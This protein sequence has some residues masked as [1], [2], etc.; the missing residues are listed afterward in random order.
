MSELLT[1]RPCGSWSTPISSEVVVRAVREITGV[2]VDGESV[3]WSELRPEEGGRT[4]IVRLDGRG[5]LHEVLPEGS[6]A[7]SAVHEYG[8]G[9]WWVRDGTVWFT[10]WADQRLYRL[11][12][13][14]V[15]EPV[16]PVPSPPRSVRWADGDVHPEGERVVVVRETHH[17]RRATE[18]VNEVVVLSLE[19]GA[20]EDVAV[21]G[22]AVG[23]G[24]VEGGVGVVVSGPDFVSTPRW[25]PDGESLC[26]LEWNHPDMP[27]DSTL[28]RVRGEDGGV[29]EVAGGPEESVFQP[30]WAPDGSLWFCSDRTGWWT[31]YRWT[32]SEGVRCMVDRPAEVGGPQWAFGTSRYDFLSD[33]RVVLASRDG[34]ADSLW[35]LS[36]GDLRELAAGCTTITSI[37][38]TRDGVVFAGGSP[39]AEPSVLRLALTEDGMGP[40]ELLSERRE[41]GLEPG[42]FSVPEHI[43][44]PGHDG[45]PTYGHYYPPTS[46]CYSVPE[47]ERPPLLVTIHGGPSGHARTTLAMGVQY[48]TSRGF[49]LVDVDYGG[50][51]GYGR[52][53]RDRLRGQWGVVDVADCVAAARWLGD[54]GRVDPDR[55]VIR[56]GSAGGFTTLMALATSEVFAAGADY[57][58]VADLEG[59]A[60]ETHKFE[61]RYLDRLIAP[62]PAGRAVYLDRSPI[63]HLDALT[64]PL[65]V[66]QGAEDQVVPPA[67]S[68]AVVAALRA[69]GVPVAYRVYDGEQHGFRRAENIRD[70]LDA[71]LSFY[72]QVL[73]FPL[74][75]GEGITP[76]AVENL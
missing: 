44:F 35:L 76:I 64:A 7:R 13:G 52:R 40:V 21:E 29:T 30:R 9:A 67:Q 39:S 31:L 2:A 72:A 8:G 42:W 55:L 11:R 51:T 73:G 33:G 36:G 34:G 66:F 41:L 54:Q 62:Y 3:Y 65:V 17:S 47:G 61:S 38:A 63:A 19:D 16:T 25:S 74:P 18:V 46:P 24:A 32:P 60:Q 1:P 37:A 57:F 5:R 10:E 59:L 22:G 48:W 68:E 15:P 6:D 14:G 49:G 43:E 23:A 4:Q 12:T 71:E 27:W 75:P 70:A 20:V 28:L 53:Y 69:R 45:R 56:G 58:G 50:S 26:W